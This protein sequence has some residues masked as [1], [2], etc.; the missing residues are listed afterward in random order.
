MVLHSSLDA[1]SI[2]PTGTVAD[3]SPWKPSTYTVTSRLMMSPSSSTRLLGMPWHTQS[4]TDVHSDLG[5]PERSRVRVGGWRRPLERARVRGAAWAAGTFVVERG[6]VGVAADDV[7]V[8]RTID[9][10]G[11]D[12]GLQEHRAVH[13]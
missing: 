5:K 10:I 11:R 8:H 2:R 9:L 3:V 12:T 13:E 6:G 1:W 4:F 7:L